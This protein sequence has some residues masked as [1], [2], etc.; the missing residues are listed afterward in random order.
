VVAALIDVDL[1][2]AAIEG[3]VGFREGSNNDNP[4][5]TWQGV[6]HA[7]YCASFAM[8]GAC[9]HGGY[10]WPDY[11]QFGWKGD[12]YCPYCEAH[13]RT[14]G[15]WRQ[16]SREDPPHR[17][18]QCLYDWTGWGGAD[19]IE[20][21][22][23]TDDGWATF[24][25]VGGNTGSP[26]GVHWVRRDW[27]YVRGFIALEETGGA[28]GPTTPR[29]LRKGYSGTDVTALQQRLVDLGY[30][31]PGGVDGDFGSGTE[32]A[33][34][35]FQHDW[36]P[37]IDGIVGESTRSALGDDGH[38]ADMHPD[39]PPPPPDAPAFPAWP[40][41]FLR[42]GD[43][44]NDVAVFQARLMERGWDE[45][46]AADGWFGRVTDRVVQQF[47]AN[48]NLTVDGIV[49]PVTWDAFWTEPVT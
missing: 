23:G 11:C 4:Y 14:L 49:G 33:V 30:D 13:A 28:P 39:P 29:D 5:G 26:Q 3:E 18:V 25:T 40:G 42:R 10:R 2:M 45:L 35:N 46:T 19:H 12:A 27:T 38:R 48:K 20:T 9:L 41:V 24:W 7:A 44:S 43:V 34:F 31:V 32:Q 22:W 6:S 8:W 16:Y 21:V 36:A 37:P 17:G 1:Q 47:Q 15:I